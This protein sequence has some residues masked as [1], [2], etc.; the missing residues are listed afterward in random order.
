MVIGDDRLFVYSISHNKRCCIKARVITRN[1]VPS[2]FRF[3]VKLSTQLSS[4]N[5]KTKVWKE[6]VLRNEKGRRVLQILYVALYK[7]NEHQ[8]LWE[9]TSL[10]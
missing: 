5:V 2:F 9:A 1:H 4:D 3:D 8:T 10:C 7:S 6:P